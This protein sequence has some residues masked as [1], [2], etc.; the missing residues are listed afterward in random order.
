M[1]RVVVF[2]F[3]GTLVDSNGVKEACLHQTVANIP[4]GAD[5][6]AAA[7][8]AGGD[9]YRIFSEVARRLVSEPEE[10]Q[11]LA[12]RLAAAYSARC[13]SGIAAAPLRRGAHVAL[14]A[15]KHRGLRLFVN[16]A[17]PERH[18]PDLL[19]VHGLL[20]H[21]HGVHGGHDAKVANLRLIFRDARCSPREVMMVGD[22]PDDLAAARETRTWFA[23]ITVE[24][25]IKERIPFAMRDLTTLVPL[26]DRLAAR[27]TRRA[28]A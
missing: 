7:R 28:F 18:L 8:L 10:E 24:N 2:D 19:R 23:G 5:A 12:R 1:I 21:L 9:R 17:T 25:R 11:T 27:P 14:R 16:S 4:G 3:D 20:E 13:A 22:G 15:L 6:L 26:I